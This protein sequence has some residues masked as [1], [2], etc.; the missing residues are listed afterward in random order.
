MLQPSLRKLCSS[1]RF[2]V[3]GNSC[4]VVFYFRCSERISLCVRMSVPVKH[5]SQQVELGHDKCVK[6]HEVHKNS[7]RTR[8]NCKGCRKQR[9]KMDSNCGY[10]CEWA[11]YSAYVALFVSHVIDIYLVS[12]CNTGITLLVQHCFC[13][14]LHMVCQGYIKIIPSQ[15]WMTTV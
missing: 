10:S 15:V 11:K 6:G 12:N 2:W 14:T 7:F 13:N 4:V 8:C 5:S 3:P 1:Y 9:W